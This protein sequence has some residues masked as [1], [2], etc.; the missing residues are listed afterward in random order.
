M[1]RGQ[2]L[3]LVLMSIFLSQLGGTRGEEIVKSYYTSYYDVACSDDCEKRGYDYYWCNTKKGWDYCSPF[4]D[5]TYK[6]EPCQSGHSCDTHSNSY[7]CKT[8]SGWDYCGLINPDE[9][10]YDTSSRKRRQ[11]NNAKL[12]CTRTDRSNK[13]ETRFYAEPAPTA[14]I[15]GSEWKYEIVNIIS[16]WDNSYLVNQA[17]SQLITTENLRID[18]QGLCVRNNQRYYNLQIQVNRPRQSGTSTTVAQVLIPQNA[19]VPS[20]YI[21]RA[22][23][24]SLNLQARVSVEGNQ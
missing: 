1:G 15:D 16:R 22:F 10:R 13:I 18:L 24:E 11:L 12:I 7:T 17:R 5:V 8:A 6:N 9:C 21:R 2:K 19:D 14:I 3:L 4:P 23:T 20:R